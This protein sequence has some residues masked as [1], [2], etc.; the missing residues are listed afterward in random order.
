[1]GGETRASSGPQ[2]GIEA[3]DGRRH[4]VE[5]LEPAAGEGQAGKVQAVQRAQQSPVLETGMV[6]AHGQGSGQYAG[7]QSEAVIVPIVHDVEALEIIERAA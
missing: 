2:R 1:M 7:L 4:P 6:V 5:I 3:A